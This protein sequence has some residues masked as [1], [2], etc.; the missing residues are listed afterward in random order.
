LNATSSQLEEEFK[1]FGPI[2]PDGVQVRSNKQQGFCY[3]FM[4]FES[5]SSMQSAIEAS[6]ITIGGCPTYV[7]EKR[8][9]GPRAI[10]GRFPPG[11]GDFA[12]RGDF[13]ARGRG[14]SGCVGSEGYQR[15]DQ[16]GNDS[17]GAWPSGVNQMS[18]NGQRVG[19]VAA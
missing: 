16:F 11:R 5:S 8:P 14:P 1:K 2:K 9:A 12:S 6:P 7:E 10:H 17:R 13:D 15:I 18:R 19:F 3:G 4:E